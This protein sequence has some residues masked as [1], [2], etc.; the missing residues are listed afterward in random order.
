MGP[1]FFVLIVTLSSFHSTRNTVIAYSFNGCSFDDSI[2]D[3]SEQCYD[4]GLFGQCS[5]SSADVVIINEPL[6][7]D[8][9]ELLRLELVRLA[10]SGLDWNDEGS[11][12]VLAYFKLSIANQLLYVPEFCQ[13]HEP[14][15]VLELLQAVTSVMNKPV[16]EEQE[17]PVIQEEEEGEGEGDEEMEV[18]VVSPVVNSSS[19][20]S[21]SEQYVP[22]VTEDSGVFA[23]ED[24]QFVDE[25]GTPISIIIPDEDVEDGVQK[26]TEDNVDQFLANYYERPDVQIEKRNSPAL[27]TLETEQLDEYITQILQNR[28]PDLSNLNEDQLAALS[29]LVDVIKTA[30]N[31]RKNLGMS[32]PEVE[33]A[34]PLTSENN[35]EQQLLLKKDIERV[36]NEDLGLSN[37]IHKIVKGAHKVHRVEGNRVYMRIKKENLTESELE[38]VIEYVLKAVAIPNG[39]WFDNFEYGDNQLSFEVTRLDDAQLMERKNGQLHNSEGV[40]KAVYKRRKDIETLSGVSVEE[41]GIGS[42]VDVV[43]V[44]KSENDHLFMPILMICAFTITALISV[45]AVHMFRTRRRNFKFELPEIA[46]H[47]EGKAQMAYEELCRQR[48][49]GVHEG[50]TSVQ[51]APTGTKSK[52]SSLS[53]WPDEATTSSMDISTGH[54]ILKFLQEFLEQPE[55]IAENWTTLE[56]SVQPSTSADESAFDQTATVLSQPLNATAIH[57]ADPGMSAYIASRSPTQETATDFWQL[58]WEQGIVLVVN[59]STIEEHPYRYWPESGSE[60]YGPYEIHLVSEHIWSEDYLVRSFYLKNIR[61]NETRTI[62]Q[63]HYLSWPMDKTPTSNKSLLEFRRKVNKSY[64]GTAAPIL[65][66]CN[67]GCGRT[68]TYCLIDTTISRIA[69]GVKEINIAGSLEYLRD[70]REG[71]VANVDQYKLVF[72]CVAEE[73]TALIKSLPQ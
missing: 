58:V 55:K 11:Q 48:M 5:T 9:K 65:V 3:Q 24:V 46:D 34:I 41:T 31:T 62:T 21:E 1:L 54:V 52:T 50:P 20:N 45:M 68:G 47:L 37:V 30:I 19:T 36:T 67:D 4:D 12:C 16:E 10:R 14:G 59:L 7:E 60:I 49:S 71:M 2:C 66:H 32:A 13:V 56:E 29:K 8:E 40:A 27:S 61:T 63:F 28:H 23:D 53:S 69:R 17:I 39:L 15:N 25:E 57:D 35:G 38:N 44:Q 51:V 73:V 43:P 33:E 26:L 42:G 72:S 18:P 6:D 70:Q 64:R 22:L